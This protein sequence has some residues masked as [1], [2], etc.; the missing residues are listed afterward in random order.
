MD[1]RRLLQ[2]MATAPLLLGGS[3]LY[4]AP[5]ASGNRLLVVFMRGAYDAASLL[6]PT[7]S[8]FYY[9]SRPSIAIARPGSGDG[10][11]L[12]LADGWGLHPALADSLL[13]FYRNKQ[14]A[15]VPFAGTEDLTRSHFETQNSIE[16]GQGARKDGNY[17]SGFLNRLTL[18]LGANGSHPAA[19]TSDVPQ[20]LRGDARVPN[21]DLGGANRKSRLS[22]ADNRAIAAMYRDT[23]LHAAVDEGQRVMGATRQELDAEM[24]AANGNAVSTDKLEKEI[25][26]IARF[27][28]DRYNVGFVDVG[29]WDTHV[30]QGAATGALAGRLGQLGRALAAYADAMGPAWGQ[31]TVVVISEFGRTFRENGNKGT[32]HGHGTVYWVMGGNVRGGRIAGRQVPVRHDTLFQDRDYPVLNEYRAVFAGLFAR[33]YGLDKARLAQV[34]PGV[35]PVD[36]GLV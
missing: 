17:R 15:F 36:I 24:Q 30:G 34:F 32:D 16:L 19:F 8:D 21:V 28:T 33:L 4:A 6:V 2:M 14:L 18:A 31:T 11:A 7:S 9:E 29:G 3:R 25:R 35:A 27:M 22:D 23:D 5:A 10:A 1:R 12:P 26:R 13:P 20:I